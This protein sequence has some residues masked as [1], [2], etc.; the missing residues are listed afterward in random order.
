VKERLEKMLGLALGFV[1]LRA[2][3]LESADDVGEFL[4]ERKRRERDNE[5]FNKLHVQ[6]GHDSAAFGYAETF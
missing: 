6:A 2:Q 3:S 5:F 1:L 4:L